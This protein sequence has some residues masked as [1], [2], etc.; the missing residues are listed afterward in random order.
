MCEKWEIIVIFLPYY[1]IQQ[2]PSIVYCFSDSNRARWINN[3]IR[4]SQSLSFSHPCFRTNLAQIKLIE[5]RLWY[6]EQLGWTPDLTSKIVETHGYR[7]YEKFPEA[8]YDDGKIINGSQQ[9][10]GLMSRCCSERFPWP[11]SKVARAQKRI[12]TTK[13]V[14]WRPQAV[15]QHTH[16]VYNCN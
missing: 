13:T 4:T 12:S 8:R 11:R 2:C 15:Q 1:Q 9:R 7:G 14:G 16:N 10:R 3:I 5:I 6:I